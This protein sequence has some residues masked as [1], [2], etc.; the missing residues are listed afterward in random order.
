MTERLHRQ[1]RR[2]IW[3]AVYGALML[4]LLRGG[5]D[6]DA[7]T[8]LAALAGIGLSV[9]AILILPSLLI[10]IDIL[11]LGFLWVLILDRDALASALEA[12]T[13]IAL[14]GPLSWVLYGAVLLAGI[15]LAYRAAK[16]TLP[17]RHVV[18][19]SR[20]I[21][22]TPE[23]VWH[24]FAHADGRP[25]GPAVSRIEGEFALG[26]DRIFHTIASNE[27][28]PERYVETLVAMEPGGSLT[29]R[30]VSIDDG[31]DLDVMHAFTV[32]PEAGGTRLA[33]REEI[34]R[35][36]LLIALAGW[37]DDFMADDLAHFAAIM[38]GRRDW[39]IK[40]A[41]L[42]AVGADTD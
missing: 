6:F 41:M 39:S 27:T 1:W 11:L 25:W 19:R 35:F 5:V 2:L 28:R 42:K 32:T 12:G 34:A 15:G 37:F 3:H 8:L 30:A 38:E 31:F 20:W 26:Q 4:A 7:G 33:V 18:E 16:L 40:A 23:Q 17:G 24:R 21:A 29:K 10:V 36:P 9:A 13:G 22:A 14:P